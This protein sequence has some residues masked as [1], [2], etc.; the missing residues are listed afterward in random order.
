MY[1]LFH[2]VASQLVSPY[3]AEKQGMNLKNNGLKGKGGGICK[4]GGLSN[5]PG[6]KHQN[7]LN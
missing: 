7:T 4:A 5:S 6:A 2:I 1:F 3:L